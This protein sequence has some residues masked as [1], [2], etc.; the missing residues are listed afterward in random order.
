M[1]KRSCEF[2]NDQGGMFMGVFE[3]SN[4]KAEMV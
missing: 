3:G 4:G 2:E 1:E